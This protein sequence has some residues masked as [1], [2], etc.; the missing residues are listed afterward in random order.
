[1]DPVPAGNT[2]YDIDAVSNS[3]KEANLSIQ[4]MVETAWAS[5]ST[6]RGSDMRG[7]ANGSRIRLEPQK[8]WEVNKPDQLQKVL[9]VYEGIS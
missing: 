7:G 8:D 3:L 9:S 2:D 5:A 6:Y 1:M 4:E